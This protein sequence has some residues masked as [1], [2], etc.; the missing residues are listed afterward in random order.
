MMME[1]CIS[2]KAVIEYL[3]EKDIIK[4]KSQEENARK[5]LEHLPSVNPKPKTDWIPV[6]ERLPKAFEMVNC[7]CHSCIDDREDWVIETC[8]IPQPYNSP[9]SNWG[10]IP[11]LNSCECEVIAWMYREIPKPYKPQKSEG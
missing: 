6:S 5:E 8:Y 4:M 1:D 7:T 11:M 3:K 10:N 2:R 9:Y